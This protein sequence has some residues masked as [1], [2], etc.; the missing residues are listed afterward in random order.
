[1]AR[2]FHHIRQRIESLINA[3][4]DYQFEQRYFVGVGLGMQVTLEP[5]WFHSD[6]AWYIG[7]NKGD[8]TQQECRDLLSPGQLDWKFGSSR[9]VEVLFKHRAE[10]LEL[11]PVDRSIRAL[12]SRQ[13]WI[14]YEVTKKDNPAW[15]DVHQ[16]QTLAVRLKDSLILNQDRLQGARQLVV[17]SHGKPATLQFALFAVPPGR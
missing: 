4:R 7:V 5:N 3:V 12:P 6:W 1:L 15:R 11:I 14:Y 17:S 9:Q 8:L 16:T 2:I 13:D 10:G